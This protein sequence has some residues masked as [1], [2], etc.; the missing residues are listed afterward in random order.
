MPLTSTRHRFRLGGWA[1]SGA[2]LALLATA[3]PAAADPAGA[4]APATKKLLDAT[5][6][7]EIIGGTPADQEAR[8]AVQERLNKAADQIQSVTDSLGDSGFAGDRIT[9]AANTVT[10]Y[11]HGELPRQVSKVVKQIERSGITV[12]TQKAKYSLK[13]LLQESDRLASLGSVN[14]AT[15]AS[16][17]PRSD[18]NGVEVAVDTDSELTTLSRA[19]LDAAL[20]ESVDLDITQGVAPRQ[21]SRLADTTP[22]WGGAYATQH[23]SSG[24]ATGACTTGFGVAGNNGAAR[25]ILTAAH[26]GGTTWR[27]GTG[28]T[29]GTVLSG[30]DPGRDAELVLGNIGNAVYEGPSIEDGDT[31][32]G[33][34]VTSGSSSR[35]GD[36]ICQGGAFSG[37]I[38]GYDI[39]AVNQTVNI[40]GFGTVTNMVRVEAANRASGIGNGDS[41]GPVYTISSSGNG[42]ARGVISAYDGSQ[43]IDCPGVPNGNG[44]DCSWRWWYPDVTVAANNLGVHF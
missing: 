28:N 1:I 20:T 3:V 39:V 8:F 24:A 5:P 19:D 7:A 27:T 38:C 26:C 34:P 6:N 31:N 33:R 35:V 30:K 16:V 22:Y 36:T 9:S 43:I 40:G 23:N 21:A 32:S 15:I 29:I 10:L 42:V 11:W 41:G 44:R 25:Y 13:Q 4:D 18:G 17:G 12:E 37:S 14:G 2:A